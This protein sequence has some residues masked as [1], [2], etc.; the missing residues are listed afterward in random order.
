MKVRSYSHFWIETVLALLAASLALLTGI[1]PEW[2]EGALHLNP[3]LHSGA[4]EWDLVLAFGLAAAVLSS[5]AVRDW[6]KAQLP[7]C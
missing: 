6:R 2:I 4:A 1:W 7:S 3:D 5:M